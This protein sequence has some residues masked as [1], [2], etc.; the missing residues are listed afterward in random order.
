M[1]AFDGQQDNGFPS[2]LIEGA[3]DISQNRDSFY[4]NQDAIEIYTGDYEAKRLDPSRKY[5]IDLNNERGPLANL[6]KTTNNPS[7]SSVFAFPIDLATSPSADTTHFMQ[8]NMYETQS[9]QLRDAARLSTLL[10][11]NPLN[12]ED[13]SWLDSISPEYIEEMGL[14]PLGYKPPSTKE[15]PGEPRYKQTVIRDRNAGTGANTT[16]VVTERI[17]TVQTVPLTREEQIKHRIDFMGNQNFRG[18]VN[19]RVRTPNPTRTLRQKKF[20]SK[21]TCFLYMPH[22]INN[23]SLQSYDTPS[24]LFASILGQSG[25][26]LAAAG[27]ALMSGNFGDAG[28][29]AMN[30][31]Q[32]AGPIAMRKAI[33]ALDSVASI[34]GMDTE[35][36]S[37]A[38]QLLGQAIN[39]R[40]ELVYNSPELRTFEFSYEFY[41]RNLKESQMV[42]AIIKMFRFHSAPALS[43]SGNFL[44]PPS[45]FTIK[46]YKRD[47]NTVVENPFLLKMRDCALTEVNVDYTPNG[48]F[49][50]F[51]SGA[52]VATT[53]SLTFKELD[54]NVKDDILE[55]Y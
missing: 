28:K 37:A 32:A 53:M 43:D 13:N 23:L 7:N 22:K 20:K 16:G 27:K 2:R 6:Y 31:I 54:I 46:F 4:N 24:L 33:G 51:G 21:D 12:E 26:A 30:M 25:T 29:E 35:L 44:V 1:T 38:T 39:P 10:S 42:E 41:P 5:E 3:K 55:G 9:A 40:K 14:T 49:S 52:P 8:F 15:V 18:G 11:E 48:N 36:E 45:I 47:T 34:I 17:D 19:Q 50:A